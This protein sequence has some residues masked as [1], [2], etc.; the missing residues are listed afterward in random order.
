MTMWLAGRWSPPHWLEPSLVQELANANQSFPQ[1]VKLHRPVAEAR[2]ILREQQR[3][4]PQVPIQ[5]TLS[6]ALEPLFFREDLGTTI[7]KRLE[8]WASRPPSS[9]A[10]AGCS[11][12]A[13][14]ECL[15]PA[16][17]CMASLDAAHAG[18]GEDD[19][20]AGST[21]Q[22]LLHIRM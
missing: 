6:R 3:E 5:R 12:Q 15:F 14:K 7:F 20:A 17:S 1:S 2:R 21:G 13:L 19:G 18:W 16:P 8:K 11:W 4:S 10:L 22:H 9:Q